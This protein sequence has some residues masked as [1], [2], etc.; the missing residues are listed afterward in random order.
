M[1]S[2]YFYYTTLLSLL[3]FSCDYSNT[4]SSPYICVLDK[5]DVDSLTDRASIL[6]SQLYSDVEY[7][8][9][10]TTESSLITMIT[11]MEIL[12]NESILVFDRMKGTVY[13]FGKDGKFLRQI[14]CKGNGHNEYTFIQDMAYDKYNNQI[15]IFDSAKNIFMFYDKDGNYLSSLRLSCF[16]SSFSVVDKEHLCLYLNYSDDIGNNST[17][18]NI[19]I[20]D[21]EG[22]VCSKWLEYGKELQHFAPFCENIF[23]QS[24]N[25][26]Y[27][28]P[29]FSNT[30]YNVSNNDVISAFSLDLGK[31]FITEDWFKRPTGEF[32]SSLSLVGKGVFV[33]SFLE[34]SSYL[35][36][37][38]SN[39][40]RLYLCIMNKNKNYEKTYV[41]HMGNDIYG[42]VSS[43]VPMTLKNDKCYNII[44]S[45]KFTRWKERFKKNNGICRVVRNG[46]LK[47][48]TPT[49]VETDLLDS[50]NDGD[51]PVVQVCT[52]K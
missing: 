47:D 21:R 13:L 45:S 33:Y 49:Q 1:K 5:I 38:I 51:N 9:L 24:D 30:I 43:I 32:E 27:I 42:F 3:L 2:L 25:N 23:F 4:F 14:G 7:I 35:F 10:E 41:A 44:D 17:G 48:I 29:P 11:K 16:P 39:R 12:D 8:P 22:G 18:H 34:S 6:Y 36:W 20:I 28:K 19:M 31:D 26:L 52:L 37:V 50:V 46:V 15:I 40:G